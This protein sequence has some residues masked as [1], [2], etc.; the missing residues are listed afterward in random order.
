[1]KQDMT[2]TGDDGKQH[3][4]EYED[5]KGFRT[6]IELPTGLIGSTPIAAGPLKTYFHIKIGSI[7][8]KFPRNPENDTEVL[9]YIL[10]GFI[11][12]KKPKN[13]FPLP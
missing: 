8:S 6:T 13:D 7:E 10:D 11:M 1:M 2:L 3:K 12:T 5:I 4:I 9:D